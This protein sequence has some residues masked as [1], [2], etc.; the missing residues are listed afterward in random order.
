ML[1]LFFKICVYS[2]CIQFKTIR[3][4]EGQYVRLKSNLPSTDSIAYSS[5]FYGQGTGSIW[6]DDV[7]CTGIEASLIDCPANAIGEHNCTHSHDAGVKC[8]VECK[9]NLNISSNQKIVCD[10][11][12]RQ[13]TSYLSCERNVWV[14]FAW[15]RHSFSLFSS[16]IYIKIAIKRSI[17]LIIKYLCNIYIYVL[18]KYIASWWFFA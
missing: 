10:C 17:W 2:I 5:A 9:Y 3:Y 8:Q 4:E 16:A 1:P 6:L 14:L 18:L 15:K 12:C 11:R 13:L 7:Q